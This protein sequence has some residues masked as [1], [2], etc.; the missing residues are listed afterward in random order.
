MIFLII[1]SLIWC[2]SFGL[3]GNTLAELPRAWIATMRLFIAMLIFIPFLKKTS[4]RTCTK[5]FG[6]G[7]I[8]FGIMYLAYMHSFNYLK[9]H[10]VALFTI[11]TPIYVSLIN[12]LQKRS[13]NLRNL[14]TAGLA[15]IGSGIILWNKESR[16]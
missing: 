6:I 13:F 9:S 2:F 16:M 8:Q 4:V 14:L 11:F 1:A 12:D 5:L 10:E 7:A 15:V 3:I